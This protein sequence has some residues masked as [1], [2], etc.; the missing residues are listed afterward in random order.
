MTKKNILDDSEAMR[1]VKIIYDCGYDIHQIT[2][3]W[4]ELYNIEHPDET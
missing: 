1:L 3:S 2:E 4:W